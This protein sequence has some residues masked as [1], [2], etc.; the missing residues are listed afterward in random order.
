MTAE[1]FKVD[2]SASLAQSAYNG[3]SFSP[4]RRGESTRNEYA[5]TMAQDWQEL[6]VLAADHG[7]SDLLPAEFERYRAGYRKRYTAYLA[8]SSRCVSWMIAGPSN[9]PARRMNKRADI[10][11]KRLEDFLDFRQRALA[12]IRRTL[13]PSLQPIMAGDSDAVERLT[14]KIE[15]AERFQEGMKVVNAAH[16]AFLK[17]PVSL[18]ALDMPESTKQRIR[19]YK[20]AYSWEPHPHAPFEL[21]N[22][23]ANIRRIKE[24][25]E[26]ISRNKT[27]EAVTVEGAAARIEDCPA[28]NRV[29]L[30]F[31]GKPDADVR[32][33]LKQGGFRWSPTIGCWQ[34]YRHNHTID[35]AKKEAGL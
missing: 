18:D 4:E 32:Q 22:N 7:T 2:I 21:T 33:R 34:A 20:P 16:K 12:A 19:N 13:T 31:P 17:N 1:T 24:R 26:Q 27:K 23:S 11:H 28:D 14:A 3:T 35:L 8:S 6:S 25:L 29:R 15:E 9:F 5:E 10:A 30:F